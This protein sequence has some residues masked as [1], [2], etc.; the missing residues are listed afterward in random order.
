M[1]GWPVVLLIQLTKDLN[2]GWEVRE[3][4]FL[5]GGRGI[6]EKGCVQIKKIAARKNKAK[7]LQ[8]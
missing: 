3:K 7:Y 2:S 4:Y 1:I 8:K 6:V 5:E